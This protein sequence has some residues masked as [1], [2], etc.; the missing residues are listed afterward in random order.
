M[1]IAYLF[2]IL[3]VKPI[4]LIIFWLFTI[5]GLYWIIK[6]KLNP[7]KIESI[8]SSSLILFMYFVAMT[9][10]VAMS[11]MPTNTFGHLDRILYLFFAPITAIAIYKSDLPY[12]KFIL[13]AKL[14]AIISGS[15]VLVE[16][17]VKNFHF[18]RLS[19]LYNANT[20]GDIAVL[21]TLLSISLIYKEN[22]KE[23]LLSTIALILGL[24]A[25]I[26]SG[27]RGSLISFTVLFTLYII[28]NL[29]YNKKG[30]KIILTIAIISIL[31]TLFIVKE[32]KGI[33]DRFGVITYQIDK[34]EHGKSKTTS[35]GAR[36]EMYTAGIKAFRKS[37]IFGYGY[38]ECGV[39]AAKYATQTKSVQNDFKGR[40]HLHDEILTSGVNAGVIGIISILLLYFVPIVF[41]IKNL[42][43]S[44]IAKAG[45]IFMVGLM[46]IG[47]THTMIG[48][49][50]ETSLIVITIIY[51]MFKLKQ[52]LSFIP[53]SNH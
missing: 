6:E 10:S 3:T 21:L 40:W 31:S 22:K 39:I 34:W 53:S 11:N 42:R 30:R 52:E 41:F 27:S 2:L 33:R 5:F 26:F 43:K 44:E 37:P 15:I 46:I 28:I 32:D 18:S 7:F 8:K 4:S 51:L 23:I 1:L 14:G 35:V 13:G 49:E 12:K 20:F 50:Y 17:I 25:I 9:I 16:A 19:G 47:T 29:I 38:Q 24:T 48:Y 45:F 36:L